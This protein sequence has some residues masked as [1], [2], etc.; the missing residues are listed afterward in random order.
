MSDETKDVDGEWKDAHILLGFNGNVCTKVVRLHDANFEGALLLIKYGVFA[1]GDR[2][3][4]LEI[5]WGGLL[6]R[7]A[8]YSNGSRISNMILFL[9]EHSRVVLNGVNCPNAI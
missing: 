7:F 4:D 5:S 2:I 9:L 6:F 8:L 3:H 1:T